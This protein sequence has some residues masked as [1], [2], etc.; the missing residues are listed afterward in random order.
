MFAVSPDDH[1]IA[2]VVSDFTASG[3]STRLYVEDLD[4]G[5]NHRDLFTETGARS[6]WPVGWHGTNNLVLAVVPSCTQG[7]GPFCCGPLELHVVDPA[8]AG[9]RFTLG[10]PSCV[11][12]GSPSP[13]GVVCEDSPG[14]TSATILSWTA[15]T[16]DRIPIAGPV[17]A[18]LAPSGIQAALVTNNGTTFTVSRNKFA[19]M[20][21]C[22][23][24]DDEHVLSG[25]DAQH[26][27]RVATPAT[28][29]VVP[30]PAEGDC[31]G[32]LP[33]GL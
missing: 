2:V 22:T 15:A 21:A 4:G 18:Y 7:G 24:I 28:G 8:T 3:A 5:G 13:A 23:W 26:Q 12:A 16:S 32:R 29:V 25:G 6:L 11:V 20:F 30:V 9:R 10:G 14:F 17:A 33:G 19:G 27:P 1:R 31:G